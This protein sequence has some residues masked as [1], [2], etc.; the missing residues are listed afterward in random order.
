[1]PAYVNSPFKTVKMLVAGHPEYLIGAWS[2]DVA[3]GRGWITSVTGNGTTTTITVQLLEGNIPNVGDFI[4]VLAAGAAYAVT[5]V[6]ISAVSITQSTGAGTISYASSYNGTGAGGSF[7][8]LP[9][10]TAETIAS[11]GSL[12]Y[13]STIPVTPQFNDPEVNIGR[14]VVVVF[15]VVTNSLATDFPSYNLQEALR[16]E[17][18]DY[19]NINSTADFTLSS[20]ITG[21]TAKTYTLQGG[22]FYRLKG[23]LSAGG[24]GAATA[25]VKIM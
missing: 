6:A 2:D 21:V 16:D 5:H 23:T 7:Q 13:A 17:D 12:S 22:R 14:T 15:N 25:V 18:S 8:V 1:M 3:L 19:V 9:A 10:E 24:S 4:S 11:A 20:G